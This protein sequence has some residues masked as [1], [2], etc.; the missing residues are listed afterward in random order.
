MKRKRLTALLL[1]VALIMMNTLQVQ[2]EV[3]VIDV[4]DRLQESYEEESVSENDMDQD[5]V[6]LDENE[7]EQDTEV[8][9]QD[10]AVQE[11]NAALEE[12]EEVLA[13]ETSSVY[14]AKFD[15]RPDGVSAI[16]DQIAG[17]CSAFGLYAAI[18]SNLIKKGLADTTVDLSEF[19]LIYF[20]NHVYSDP[21][22]N[23]VGNTSDTTKTNWEL[24]HNINV[25]RAI[26]FLSR[27][28]GPVDESKAPHG[29][30]RWAPSNECFTFSNYDEDTIN[31]MKLDQSLCTAEYHFK[32]SRTCTYSLNNLDAIKELITT[33]GGVRAAY[34]NGGSNYAPLESGDTCYYNAYKVL[35]NH[36]VEFVGWDDDFPASN[37]KN[38]YDVTPPGNGAWLAKNSG[39]YYNGSTGYFWLSYYEKSICDIYAVDFDSASTYAN[40]YAYGRAVDHSWASGYNVGAYAM[41]IFE[42]K[43]YGA[44][45][46]EKIDGVMAYFGTDTPY[47]LTIY[48]NPV[49]E[50]GK[51]VSYSGKSEPVTGKSDYEGYYTIDLRDQNIYVADGNTYGICM[52]VEKSGGLG[53]DNKQDGDPE[54]VMF[55]GDSLNDLHDVGKEDYCKISASASPVG[56]PCLRGL[57]NKADVV[58]ATSI[59]LEADSMSLQEG[60][61]ATAAVREILPTNTT[62]KTYTYRSTDE[63]VATV[64]QSGRIAAVGYGECDITVTTYDGKSDSCHVNVCCT[65]LSLADQKILAGQTGAMTPVFQNDYAG[66]DNT[67]L[68]WS[69]SDP[70]TVAVDVNGNITAKKAGT[71]TVTASLKDSIL[72]GGR[73]ITASCKIT[74]ARLTESINVDTDMIE[75]HEGETKQLT[76]SVLPTDTS[77]KAVS[78]SSSTAAVTVD[79]SGKI[80]AAFAGTAAITITALDGSGISKTINVAVKKKEQSSVLQP[81]EQPQPGQSADNRENASAGQNGALKERGNGLQKNHVYKSG[82]GYYSVINAERALVCFC[83]PKNRK[84][85]AAIIPDSIIINDVKCKVISIADGAFKNNKKL[86]SVV[87]GKNI[88]QI[89]KDAF[90]GCENLKNVRVKTSKLSKVGKKAFSKINKNASISVPKKKLEIYT[91]LM[92]GKYTKGVKIVK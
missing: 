26:A 54:G 9:D 10:L 69:S 89:G 66:I 5:A 11:E 41:N 53:G 38:N 71:V 25:E 22:G 37:F 19:Q 27:W 18:E 62:N 3:A 21:L 33:Y 7:A 6:L 14:P 55:I 77:N 64:D 34:C 15:P 29:Y 87:I 74:V 31:A 45:T 4:T 81:T 84:K 60:E 35:R 86:K 52:K 56:T 1:S 82:N 70:A 17:T 43:A 28:N 49:V 72:T 51:L 44:G 32:G 65:G 78:F 20:M 13:I 8:P 16:R 68:T 92:K 63:S 90:Y 48:L 24:L 57:T 23:Y 50:D 88:L 80:T 91:R 79:Q 36:A 61:S 30:Y 2:A 83:R 75:L 46:A 59:T 73:L 12:S 47:E 76:V 39:G 67:Q 40:M 42:A 58:L 85:S